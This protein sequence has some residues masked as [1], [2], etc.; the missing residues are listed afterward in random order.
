MEKHIPL[1]KSE[2]SVSFPC[3]SARVEATTYLPRPGPPCHR[4]HSTDVMGPPLPGTRDVQ[5]Q[6]MEDALLR[7]TVCE[8]ED[9]EPDPQTPRE[10]HGLG[11]KPS[12][13][14]HSWAVIHAATMD[15]WEPETPRRP[16]EN[17]VTLKILLFT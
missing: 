4:H 14:G 5:V 15:G 6:A 16:L 17:L 9:A 7:V 12:Q 11:A 3:P 8:H 2:N 1:G 13:G 10:D